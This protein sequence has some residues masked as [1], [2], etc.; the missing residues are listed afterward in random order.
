MP[1]KKGLRWQDLD[2]S[3]EALYDVAMTSR[4]SRESGPVPEFL[5]KKA[6]EQEAKTFQWYSESLM[7]FWKYLESRGLGLVGDLNE[8]NVNLFRLHLRE[9]GLSE[10]TVSNRLRALKA[11]SRWMGKRGWTDGNA[12]EDLRVPQSYRPQFDLIPD[13]LRRNLFGLYKPNTFLGARNIAMLAVLS[14]TGM[15]REELAN[16]LSANVDMDARTIKVFSDKTEE[17]RYVPMTDEAVALVKNYLTWK[18]RYF[19]ETSRHRINGEVS[20]RTRVPRVLQSSHV[21]VTA[22]GKDVAPQAVT[23]LVHRAGKRLGTRLH[24]HLFRHDW[25]TRKAIDGEN[26]SLVKRWAGHK[27]YAMTDYYFGVAE[28]M[29]GA[30]KPKRSVL[31]TIPLPG[32]RKRGRPPKAAAG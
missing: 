11:F 6:A 22:E 19:S 4:A 20:R 14:D 9:K 18:A 2:H 32:A 3:R 26:P 29:L 24:P 7:Q 30:I 28:Q 5:A 8:H 21:F 12:L 16:L 13:D 15:R 10:N 23:L 31:A 1:G 27:S 25:I 17:W